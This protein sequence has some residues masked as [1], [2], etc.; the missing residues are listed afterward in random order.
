MLTL[1]RRP[2][3]PYWI[4]RGTINGVRF[5]R[6]TGET[7][8]PEA[9]KKLAAIVDE[10]NAAPAALDWRDMTFS[11]AMTAYLDN[12]RDARFLDR[13]LEHFQDTPLG[14][15]D[16]AAMSRAA[17]ALYPGR[18]PATI[19]RQLYVP[20][21]AIINFVKDDKLRAPKG[22]G[23]RTIFMTPEEVERLI[24]VA[25]S[26]PSI[27]LA[28][29]VTF[30]VGTGARVGEA[31]GL[32]GRDVNLSAQYA[33]LRNTKNGHERTV[34]L[35]PRV[36][37]A[38]SRLPTVGE[39]GKV[40]RRY[41]GKDFKARTRRGGHIRN[42]FAFAVEHAGL[43]EAITPHVCRHTWATWHYAVN[44]DPLALK[45]EGGWLSNEYQRYV[46][47]APGGLA[48]AINRHGWDFAG[49]NRGSAGNYQA[50]SG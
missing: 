38:L 16:N 48:E 46:K 21:T 8:K 39:K 43:P 7:S 5:E 37:A 27:Y 6:S 45:R 33:I 11:R 10:L 41:D 3:S 40:F 30:L 32:N 26:Q 44:R 20:V 1:T 42:P 23:Q 24:R 12:D 4:A 49:E 50:I 9:R 17:N 18:A 47:A 36:V 13:L 14:A 15:I 2:K 25:V 19:R 34:T 22:G 28:P 31:I 35:M 29:M